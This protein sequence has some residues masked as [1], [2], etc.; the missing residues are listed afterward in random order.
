MAYFGVGGELDP[1]LRAIR[2]GM[3][4]CA[5]RDSASLS[6]HRRAG[7]TTEKSMRHPHGRVVQLSRRWYLKPPSKLFNSWLAGVPAVLGHE[8]AYRAERRSDLDYIEVSLRMSTRRT[9]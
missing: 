4:A 7:V 2:P 9:R 1:G 6:S 8:S 5:T 3:I